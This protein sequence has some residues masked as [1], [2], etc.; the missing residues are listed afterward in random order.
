MPFV[1]TATNLT[2]HAGTYFYLTPKG[3]T[4][5]QRR[6]AF[7]A[8]R[9]IVGPLASLREA[10]PDILADALRAS[11][12]IPVAFDPVRITSEDGKSLEEYVDGGVVANTPINIARAAARNV[13]VVLLDPPFDSETYTGAASIGLG[14]FGTMQRRILEADLRAAFLE[15]FGKRTLMNV[16]Q[17]IAARLNAKEVAGLANVRKF[18]G[19]LVAANFAVIRPDRV[20]PVDVGGFDDGPNIFASYKLGFSDATNRGFAPYS[21]SLVE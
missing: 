12:A 9:N 6:R 10:T 21:Y 20:L 2:K 17:S 14:V 8:V 4:D 1:F 7:A 19:L 18:A 16:P 15:S 11:T 3:L 5:E 13:D